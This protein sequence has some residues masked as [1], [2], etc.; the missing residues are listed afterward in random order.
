MDVHEHNWKKWR[1]L[2]SVYPLAGKREMEPG[3]IPDHILDQFEPIIA[4]LPEYVRYH[5]K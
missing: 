4:E 5:E 2:K 3:Q 1:Q